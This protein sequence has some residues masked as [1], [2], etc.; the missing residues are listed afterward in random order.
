M[1]NQKQF[2]VWMDTHQATV[3]ATSENAEKAE[4][5]ILAHVTG[6]EAAPNSNEKTEQNHKKSLQAKF[7]KEISAHL[8]NATHVHITGTGQVQEQFIHYLAETPQFKNTQT[9]EST[10]NKMSDEK[11]LTFF[12]DK[13][14]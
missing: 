3:V 9:A 11:L 5:V 4:P 1:A 13:L 6:E 2:G 12:A 8:Q 14:N 7:F 10:S